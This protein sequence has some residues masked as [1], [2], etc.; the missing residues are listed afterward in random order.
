LPTHHYY[1]IITHKTLIFRLLDFLMDVTQWLIDFK[2]SLRAR[3]ARHNLKCI[4][5]DTDVRSHRRAWHKLAPLLNELEAHSQQNERA[6]EHHVLVGSLGDF[7][8]RAFAYKRSFLLTAVDAQ[9]ESKISYASVMSQVPAHVNGVEA[10][11]FFAYLERVAVDMR[12]KGLSKVWTPFLRFVYAHGHLTKNAIC[13]GYVH[14]EN[15]ASLRRFTDFVGK[16]HYPDLMT[17]WGGHTCAAVRQ[18]RLRG[19]I[20][21]GVATPAAV[22]ERLDADGARRRCAQALGK[23]DF[24]PR[25]DIWTH[26]QHIAMLQVSDGEHTLVGSVWHLDFLRLQDGPAALKPSASSSSPTAHEAPMMLHN[27]WLFD[28]ASGRAVWP[29]HAS[30]RQV[31]MLLSL[32]DAAHSDT[33]LI[34]CDDGAQRCWI[35]ALHAM[36]ASPSPTPV[37]VIGFYRETYF[38]YFP[39]SDKPSD[40]PNTEAGYGP[41]FLDPRHSSSLCFFQSK[42][43]FVV[44]A[45]NQ[46][47]GDTKAKL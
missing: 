30:E 27:L 28:N 4:L 32:V 11:V 16:G 35:E 44:D 37:D 12:G 41:I 9:Q 18:P 34:D 5:Y 45:S 33:V 36:P 15:D 13:G 6:A 26:E 10:D 29:R 46:F 17:Q 40:M 43:S 39:F 14:V 19:V 47:H 21:L 24:V 20:E 1:L 7:S 23:A 2:P 25:D 8:V 31:A 3:L 38:P 22:V 42:E